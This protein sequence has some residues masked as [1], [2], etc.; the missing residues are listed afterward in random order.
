M[1]KFFLDLY[2]IRP[3]QLYLDQ[4][5]IDRLQ[6]QFDPLNIRNNMPLPVKKIGGE[7]FLTDGHTR[8]Y[9]YDCSKIS[10]IPVY[11]D[12][13]DLDIEVYQTCLKWCREEMIMFISDLKD[14]I[15]PHDQFV[16]QWV[17]RCEA[18]SQKLKKKN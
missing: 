2:Q 3:S 4:S 16:E 12:E 18:A 15:L 6:G 5:K 17:N 11:W 14:R 10:M 8:A 9:L 13:D 1:Q 7:V